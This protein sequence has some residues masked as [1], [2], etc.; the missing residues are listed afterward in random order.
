MEAGAC[1]TGYPGHCPEEHRTV[2]F[3]RQRA[4]VPGGERRESRPE[5]F[6][7]L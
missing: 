5:R 7:P 3:D 6:Q 4:G 2:G 1:G